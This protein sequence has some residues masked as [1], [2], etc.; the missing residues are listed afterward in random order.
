VAGAVDPTTGIVL[1]YYDILEAWRPVHEALDHRDLN[2][3]EGL[4][5]PTTEN[6][7]AYIWRKMEGALAAPTHK[8]TKLTI[9]EGD[10][11]YCEFY[12]AL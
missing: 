4:G 8:L 3:V 7:A 9:Y 5:L 10:T 2:T 6:I 11:D 12:G 1:D